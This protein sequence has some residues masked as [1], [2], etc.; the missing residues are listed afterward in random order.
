MATFQSDKSKFLLSRIRG[1]TF[2]AEINFSSENRS[3]RRVP[4]RCSEAT[5]GQQFT[6]YAKSFCYVNE[7]WDLRPAKGLPYLALLQSP[8]SL[9]N[10]RRPGPALDSGL[11]GLGL[12][13]NLPG[14]L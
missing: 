7:R 4:A 13:H 11:A 6:S 8:G 3:M 1:A 9:R 5:S 14:G 12:V 2:R 10:T